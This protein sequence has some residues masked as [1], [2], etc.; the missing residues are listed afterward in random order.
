VALKGGETLS[1][2]GHDNRVGVRTLALRRRPVKHP[3]E[4]S[5]DALFGRTDQLKRERRFGRS[6]YVAM[7][8][9]VSVHG[10]RAGLVRHR[11]KDLAALV[12]FEHEPRSKL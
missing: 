6:A 9:S 7:W 10:P 3:L 1:R 12:H 8:V 2:D 11:G 5:T 4:E